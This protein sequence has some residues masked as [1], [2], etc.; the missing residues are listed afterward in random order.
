MAEILAPDWSYAAA[1]TPSDA[2][3]NCTNAL[4]LHNSG[5][6]GAVPLIFAN[7]ATATLHLAQGATLR[8][9][10]WRR[11]KATGLG[12]GVSIVAFY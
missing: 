1:V 2:A 3:D 7:G 4:Y 11:V 9:G 10:L 6:A 12:A 5:T 8:G